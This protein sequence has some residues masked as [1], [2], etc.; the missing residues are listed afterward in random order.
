MNTR[1]RIPFIDPL[2]AILAAFGLLALSRHLAVMPQTSGYRM[3]RGI[4]GGTP[5]RTRTAKLAGFSS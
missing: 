3:E 2:L 5:H 4:C 1:L